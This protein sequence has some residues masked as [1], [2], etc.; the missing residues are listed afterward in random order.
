MHTADSAKTTTWCTRMDIQKQRRRK[1]RKKNEKKKDK[2][3]ARE[4]KIKKAFHHAP[5][6]ALSLACDTNLARNAWTSFGFLREKLACVS[7]GRSGSNASFTRTPIP[8][9]DLTHKN[10]YMLYKRRVG[11]WRNR[12][13]SKTAKSTYRGPCRCSRWYCHIYCRDDGCGPDWWSWRWW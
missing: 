1:K 2:N 3:V 12:W 11:R 6:F 4:Q 13:M 7:G 9:E 10:I 8:P 5:W